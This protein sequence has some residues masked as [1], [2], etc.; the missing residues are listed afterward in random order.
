MKSKVGYVLLIVLTVFAF[1]FSATE[2]AYAEEK[3]YLGGI[4][5]GIGLAED[6]L[7]V[8]GTVDVITDE[9]ARCPARGSE[10]LTGDLIVSVNGKSISSARDFAS[11]VQKADADVTLTVKRGE[12]TFSVNLIPVTDT[13][14]GLKK[15]GLILKNGINGIGTLTFVTKESLK[16]GALGHGIVDGDTGKLFIGDVGSL[17]A[18]RITGCKRAEEG[19]AGQLIGSFV[20]REHPIGE[21]RRC[22]AFGVYGTASPQM[23]SGLIE[24]PI[25]SRKEIKTGDALIYSTIEGETPK[26]YKIEIIKTSSQ[27]KP[28]EKGMLIR[29]TDEALLSATGGILQG[30]SGS[31]IVQNG[32]LVGAVTHVLVNDSTLGYGLYLDWML[33]NAA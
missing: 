29:V 12:Q 31:P 20:D 28:Q 26:A 22:D 17:Y 16:F 21:I 27:K 5:I 8:T 32:K 13:L 24:I 4:P 19:K 14:T 23:T 1:T 10:I 6:G 18:C 3:V 2:V 33:Q 11:E 15:L 30:M 25:A 7:I 9:G